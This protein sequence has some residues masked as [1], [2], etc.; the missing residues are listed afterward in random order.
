MSIDPTARIASGAQLA[1]GVTVGAYSIIGEHVSLGE[2]TQVGSHVLITG[3]SKV[4]A[5]NRISS[6]CTL[7]VEPQDLKY[8]GE[9]SSLVIGDDNWIREYC[10]ISVGTEG[11]GMVT[12]I[13]S[14]NLLM[15]RTHIG[16]DVTLADHCILANGTSL[17]GHVQLGCHVFLGGHVGVHQYC[18]LGDYSMVSAGS[19]LSQDVPPCVV[20]HGHRAA[21]QGINTVLLKRQNFSREEMAEVKK[22]YRILYGEQRSFEEARQ[23]IAALPTS[24]MSSLFLEF[25]PRVSRGLI[26]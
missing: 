12:R 7:G 11:G 23:C 25:F 3:R 15:V 1:A 21:P 14:G 18:A 19:Y 5:R 6:F 24:R 4:G 13:G 8:K 22:I 9:P 26:R 10:N 16:H 2:S 20:A 17:A